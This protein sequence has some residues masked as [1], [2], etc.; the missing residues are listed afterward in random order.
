MN[1]QA[2]PRKGNPSVQTYARPSRPFPVGA[3][4]EDVNTWI[5]ARD[6]GALAVMRL[7]Y[8]IK[9]FAETAERDLCPRFPVNSG[10]PKHLAEGAVRYRAERA[11]RE[12]GGE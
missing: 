12:R 4:I 10:V 5:P 2:Q 3:R 1:L 6:A 8:A 7:A 9:A 11:Q